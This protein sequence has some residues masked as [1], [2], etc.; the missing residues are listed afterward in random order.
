MTARI[1]L[2]VQGLGRRAKPSGTVL[3]ID[4]LLHACLKLATSVVQAQPGPEAAALA[5]LAWLTAHQVY[6]PSR[7]P[8]IDHG[9]GPAWPK[10]RP[11]TVVKLIMHKNEKFV[12]N[13]SLQY[14]FPEL[15]SGVPVN[16]VNRYDMSLNVP[17]REKSQRREAGRYVPYALLA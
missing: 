17:E 11:T 8:C 2:L 15:S 16:S 6:E 3:A 9:L 12:G 13:S 7:G 14:A 4:P 10:L 5:W 1:V